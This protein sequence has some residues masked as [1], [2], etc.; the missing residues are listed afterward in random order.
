MFS[1]MIVLA[2]VAMIVGPAIVSSIQRARSREQ[3]F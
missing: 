1:F 2:F 3:D